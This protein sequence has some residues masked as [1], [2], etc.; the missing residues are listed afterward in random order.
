MDG[1]ANG[2]ETMPC[3]HCGKEMRRG[4]IRCRECG[5]AISEGDGDFVLTGHELKSSQDR[6][7]PR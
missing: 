1:L 7:C 5:K 2:A 6:K 4:M 3:P